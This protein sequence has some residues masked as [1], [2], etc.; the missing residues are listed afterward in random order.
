M[1][2]TWKPEDHIPEYIKTSLSSG[3]KN[4]VLAILN[5]V[6]QLKVQKRTGWVNHGINSPESISDHMYRMGITS[7]LI[8][9]PNVNRDKCVRIS[10][11]HDLAESLVG[12]I[13]PYD[14]MTKEEKHRREYETIKYLCK[15][16]ISPFNPT[17]AK[18]IEE[19]WVAYETVSSLEARYVKD[20]DKFEMLVQ[21]FEYEQAH[22]VR[23]DQFWSAVSDIKTDEVTEWCKDLIE[24]RETY[25]SNKQ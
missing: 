17:A 3:K 24:Q 16:I 25:F 6:Q 21:A 10:L 18:E 5:I 1:S 19:D 14:P 11:V 7:M 15:E 12:D 20:I 23:L 4:Y 22:N 9:N 2:V 8:T 13:T